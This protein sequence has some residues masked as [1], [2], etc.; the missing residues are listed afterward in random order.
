MK[1][2]STPLSKQ[3]AGLIPEMCHVCAARGSAS[4]PARTH[5]ANANV[6][7]TALASPRDAYPTRHL[8]MYVTATFKT[9]FW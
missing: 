5:P 6:S 9:K 8:L 1:R 3:V 7:L 2:I 4:G